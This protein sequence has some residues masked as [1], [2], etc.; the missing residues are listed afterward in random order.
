MILLKVIIYFSS[1]FSALFTG[2][3]IS[4]YFLILFMVLESIVLLLTWTQNNIQVST[5]LTFPKYLL[6][7][8][9]L[10]AIYLRLILNTKI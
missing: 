7:T 3:L 4:Q 6:T 1:R 10:V 8:K 5:Y 9:D 2:F